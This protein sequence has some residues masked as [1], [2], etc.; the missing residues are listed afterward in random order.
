MLNHIYIGWF[1]MKIMLE[2]DKSI[3]VLWREIIFL[4]INSRNSYT[5]HGIIKIKDF[6]IDTIFVVFVEIMLQQTIHSRKYYWN[7]QSV[8]NYLSIMAISFFPHLWLISRFTEYHNTTGATS[9]AWAVHPTVRT[10]VFCGVR[11]VLSLVFGVVFI[12]DYYLLFQK[13]AN[14]MEPNWKR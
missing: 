7:T 5:E 3:Y 8:Y 1:C 14:I 9:G 11:V 6:L 10:L 13:I 12:L 2:T 4:N